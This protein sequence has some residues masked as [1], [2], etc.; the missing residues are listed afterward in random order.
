MPKA[1][2]CLCLA[3]LGLALPG[4]APALP[5]QD[6][7]AGIADLYAFVPPDAPQTVALI[8]TCWP[9]E[10]AS[11]PLFPGFDDPVIYSL[12]VDNDGDCVADVTYEFR[13]TTTQKYPFSPFYAVGAIVDIESF[14]P[15]V[16]QFYSV[17]RIDGSGS[18]VLG[19]G[20]RVPPAH[21]GP[22]TTPD[23]PFLAGQAEADTAGTFVFCGPRDD[24]AF[25][26]A[27]L[28]DLFEIR[29]GLPG[30]TGGGVDAR[31]GFNVLAICLRIPV[32]ELTAGGTVP[33]DPLDPD[34]ILGVW[35]TTSRPEQT[36][37]SGGAPVHSGP[38]IPMFRRGMPLV[39]ELMMGWGQKETYHGSSPTTD[40]Q[41]IGR[42]EDPEIAA[43]L[44]S[45][46]GMVPPPTPRTDL[47][48]AYLSGLAGVNQIPGQSCDL[49]RLNVAVPPSASEHRLGVLGG[50]P[51]GFPN[52][53]RPA[54]DVVDVTLRWAAGALVPGYESGAE[55][56]DGLDANDLPFPGAFPYLA[57]PH[58][59]YDHTHHSAQAQLAVG[60][61]RPPERGSLLRLANRPNPFR[62]GTRVEF[63]L[64]ERSGAV[65]SFYDVLGR[66]VERMEW[67]SL[68]AGAHEVVPGTRD[69][70]SGTYFYVL[71]TGGR[72]ETRRMTLVR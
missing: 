51:A 48:G 32:A 10:P 21:V 50:D 26:D 4:V 43:L 7:P 19:T 13:F 54:D 18:A 57:G 22:L 53:R 2:P 64:P 56:G 9:R 23:Y 40:A 60:G 63:L 29:P 27:A 46:H 5:A 33:V 25:L 12:H 49:L 8:A 66:L 35:A 58:S 30:T 3:A 47:S 61:E 20:L 71:R 31:G 68:G 52:G 37:W 38:L 69:W 72:I 36:D 15:N 1:I 11:G 34:A 59:G 6:P 39:E 28:F 16:E 14:S 41:F 67:P 62:A 42:F 55:I 70:P 65:L 44:A 17:T 45:E 24:P